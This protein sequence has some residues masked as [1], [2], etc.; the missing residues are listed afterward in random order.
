[1]GA[2]EFWGSLFGH[3]YAKI[4][5]VMVKKKAK[6]DLEKKFQK[7][8]DTPEG[9]N[10]FVA[11]H[12]FI[13]HIESS[14]VLSSAVSS[15]ARIERKTEIAKKYKQ[16]KKVYRAFE[17]VNADT[18]IDLG[19]ERYMAILDLNKIKDKKISEMNSFWKKRD[20]YRKITGE[21]YEALVLNLV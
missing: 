9:F 1:L 15:S 2:F 19:H 13:K 11:I 17:D 7:I 14:E 16:L 21:V 12:D 4:L 18:D 8:S 20:L 10:F 5:K 6:K 3:I